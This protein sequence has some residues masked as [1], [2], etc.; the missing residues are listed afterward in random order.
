MFAILFTYAIM[1]AAE[2]RRL[3]SE[4]EA[5]RVVGKPEIA[6]TNLDPDGR[7]RALG[8]TWSASAERPPIKAGESVIVVRLDG[9]RLIVRLAKATD[10]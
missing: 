8:E 4:L 9:I 10:E 7:V 2:A 1:K 6:E 5:E 3:K